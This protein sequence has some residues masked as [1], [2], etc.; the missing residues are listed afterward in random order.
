VLYLSIGVFSKALEAAGFLFL[1]Y[2]YAGAAAEYTG[3]FLL[4]A[5][6]FTVF[7]LSLLG[8]H[9]YVMIMVFGNILTSLRLPVAP[10]A[11]ATALAFGSSIS[12]MVSPFAG[13]VLTCAKYLDVAPHKIGLYW[14]G[15]FGLAYFILGSLA[16]MLAGTW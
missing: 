7:L 13:I 10:A 4:P 14:N 6:S 8:L 3:I 16:I 5:V 9:P 11:I 15:L 1:L 12:Y 2:P